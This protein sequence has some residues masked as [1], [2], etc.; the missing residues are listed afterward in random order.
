MFFIYLF[1]LM[2]YSFVL[3]FFF[4][5]LLSQHPSIFFISAILDKILFTDDRFHN[6]KHFKRTWAPYMRSNCASQVIQY[7]SAHTEVTRFRCKQLNSPVSSQATT[8]F[9]QVIATP[10]R[11]FIKCTIKM[12]RYLTSY[13]CKIRQ[14]L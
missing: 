12:S 11:H 7:V 14:K 6:L 8:Q 9:E 2:F 5:L 10:S 13:P 4:S 3:Y 1:I